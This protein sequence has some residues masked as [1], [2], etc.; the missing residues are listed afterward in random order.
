ML[1]YHLRPGGV[2]SVIEATLPA[3]AARLG[4]ERIVFLTGEAARDGWTDRMEAQF[5]AGYFCTHVERSLGYFSEQ[6][7]PPR[8][9]R[10]RIQAA[11]QA[12]IP[13]QD[14]AVVWFHNPGLGR[15]LLVNQCV[16]AFV[17]PTRA[18]LIFHHHDFWVEN[19]WS[20]WVE[21]RQAGFRTLNSVASAMFAAGTRAVHATITSRDARGLRLPVVACA[22]NPQC[23]ITAKSNVRETRRWLASQLGDTRPVWILPT[24]ILRRKN[25]AEAALIA[26]WLLP[27]GWLVAF[28]GE[29]S[30]GE[31][32]FIRRLNAAASQNR[33]RVVFHL[34]R[35]Q[36]SP[37]PSALIA[38]SE[39]VLLTSVQEGFGLAFLEA[40]VH[41]KPLI[42]RRLS[43]V[44][45]DLDALGLKFPHLYDDVLVPSELFDLRAERARQHQ[46]FLAA[47]SQIPAAF[48]RYAKPPT[49]SNE[50]PFS[51]LTL[52]AQL[53]VLRHPPEQSWL[54]C[55]PLN[56]VL[57][58][59]AESGLRCAHAETE[60]SVSPESTAERLAALLARRAPQLSPHSARRALDLLA[61]ERLAPAHRFPIVDTA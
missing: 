22:P 9:I 27:D 25:P 4:V 10:R 7:D 14:S 55:R 36:G 15:N 42:A 35:D 8:E 61:K 20:R 6:R 5:A 28:G 13:D 39:A 37:S 45:P 16:A 48:R 23:A 24:R 18:R 60:I 47:R 31:K 59:I 49:F 58:Q 17:A 3:L 57:N 33:W 52:D 32:E 56:P 43:N 29:A 34:R 1:H 30:A 51:R 53:E 11:L 19:R 2:R 12:A 41:G 54:A 40:T 26:R 50:M 21:M 46:L 38:A 44:Q